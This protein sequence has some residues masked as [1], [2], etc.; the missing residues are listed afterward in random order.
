MVRPNQYLHYIRE[1]PRKK[2]KFI[3]SPFNF[4]QLYEVINDEKKKTDWKISKM[5]NTLSKL[6]SFEATN[7]FV[8]RKL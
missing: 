3:P 4:E 1:L 8:M 7:T 2:L 5:Y 6:G